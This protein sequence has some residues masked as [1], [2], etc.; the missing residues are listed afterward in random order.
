MRGWVWIG[1]GAMLASCGGDPRPGNRESGAG[2]AAALPAVEVHDSAGLV[3]R[4][5]PRERIDAV[6]WHLEA[7]PVAVFDGSEGGLEPFHLIA[8]M[9]FDSDTS[10]VLGEMAMTRLRRYTLEGFHRT[11]G[12]SG[13]GPGEFGALNHIGF[14]GDS[15]LV[16]D[17]RWN[18]ISVF[19]GA[20][21][22]VRSFV[23]DPV[24]G[25]QARFEGLFPDGRILALAAVPGEDRAWGV[26]DLEGR[27]LGLLQGIPGLP[28]LTLRSLA[29]SAAHD[30]PPLR[31]FRASRFGAQ[32]AGRFVF[33][34]SG[35]YRFDLHDAQGARRASER[36]EL[37]PRPLSEERR[38]AWKVGT[39]EGMSTVTPAF[40]RSVEEA[41]F[42]ETLPSL[43]N[44]NPLTGPT[45]V[46]D[47]DQGRI[48]VAEYPAAPP[49]R[50]FVFAA[51]GG[52]AGHLTLPDGF[53]LEAVRGD[54]LL[55]VARDAL[56]RQT[57]VVW[58][59]Q[60]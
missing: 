38:E 30:L 40:R 55:G 8:S 6:E 43:G 9:A 47:D 14:V 49:Q 11:I 28:P 37:P 48:W 24:R 16:F 41:E 23:L 4:T 29:P 12:R 21:E 5:S 60:R 54:L 36:L 44:G 59:L 42:P 20:F 17:S 57:A 26:W 22:F 58:R 7:A 52:L 50:W 27:S 18:R 35:D 13:E 19:D 3:V 25:G 15:L 10:F 34:D 2:V 31:P 1:V 45:A 32:A 46:L 51:E 39:L 53:E 56:D 33:I